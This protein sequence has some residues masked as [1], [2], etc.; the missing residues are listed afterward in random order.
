LVLLPF[1]AGPVRGQTLAGWYAQKTVRFF[2]I[3]DP[4]VPAPLQ[5]LVPGQPWTYPERGPVDSLRVFARTRDSVVWLGGPRGAAR[6]DPEAT[7]RWER[8]QYFAGRRWLPDDE[9][10]QIVIADDRYETA[11][12]RT[13]SGVTRIAFE[14]MTLAEKEHVF[15][16]VIEARHVRHGFVT[17][18]KLTRPGDLSS[19]VTSD[20]D[21]DGLWTAMYLA[22]Q[23]FRYQVTG[24]AE[25]GE[26]ARRSFQALLRLETVDPIPGLY[27]RT[28]RY[29]D[30]PAPH[31]DT[32]EWHRVPGANLEW[33]GDTSSDESVGHYFAFSVYFDLVADASEKDSLRTHVR[34]ITD[35]LIDH[36]Y[37]LIDVDGAPTRW[38]RWGEDYFATPEGDYERALRALELLSF[39]KTAHHITGDPRYAEAYADRVDRGYARFVLEYRRWGSEEWEINYSDDELYY[40]SIYPLL[41]YETDPYLR[42]LYQESLRFTWAQVQPERNPLWNYFS[43]ALGAGPLTS[44]LAAESRLALERTPLELVE[45]SVRNSHRRD[46]RLNRAPDRHRERGLV[47]V[48]A[49]D[50]R[51][52]HK[53]N[54]NP[55][56]A[57]GGAGGATE[58]APTFWLLPYWFGRFAGY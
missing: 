35:Y 2:S 30:E 53:H 19:S 47:Y 5:S 33:K 37:D 58:E 28:Y 29:L 34:R 23:A 22:A 56:V 55:Y 40:L 27:A 13:A 48:V 43:A 16:R 3:D 46:V 50:E 44:T 4:E 1:V 17:R 57:D 20:D 32:G 36:G 51:R 12:I 25:A 9:V 14:P 41:R 45:W 6:F 7:E 15:D 18:S 8:W 10:R 42:A 24:D 31:Q 39:L 54:G 49:P 11:W 26:R 38:G 21:N 52:V